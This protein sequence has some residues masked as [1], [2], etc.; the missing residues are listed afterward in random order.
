[1][2]DTETLPIQPVEPGY[3]TV[4]RLHAL[5]L[6]TPFTVFAIVADQLLLRGNDLPWGFLTVALLLLALI[7]VV[8]VPGRKYRRLGYAMGADSLRV[9]RG[10][11][12]HTDTVVPF[13][14]VQHI[15]VGQG[16][17]ERMAGVAHLVVHTA[18]THNSVV[19]LPGL[20]HDAAIAMRDTIRAHIQTD[21][22]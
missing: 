18:G 11:M 20:T 10:M 16:P 17:I 9:V 7:W 19:T 4:L 6:A 2:T 21:F 5:M 1:M 14:R 15:D 22:A 12:F 13:V 8:S 3:R